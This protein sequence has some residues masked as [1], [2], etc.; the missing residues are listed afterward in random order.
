VLDLYGPTALATREAVDEQGKPTGKRRAPA[1]SMEA[2]GATR[3]YDGGTVEFFIAASPVTYVNRSSPPV[4]ILQ[5][6]ADTEVDPGQPKTLA[7]VLTQHRVP[8]EIHFVEGA[9]HGFDFES[10]RGKPLSRDLRPVVLAFLAK[11][12]GPAR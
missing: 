4:L 7:A 6:T 5:G 10:W 1:N 2:F 8:H 12:L 3:S 9:G 11:H